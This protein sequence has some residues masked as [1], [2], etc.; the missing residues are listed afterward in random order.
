MGARRFV[1]FAIEVWAALA[2]GRRHRSEVQDQRA[3]RSRR[4]R[5]RRGRMEMD[6]QEERQ[7]R[8][9]NEDRQP[10]RGD[11]QQYRER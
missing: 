10:S 9:G 6:P 3:G 5:S 8:D 11:T 4:G 2:E 7:G 1:F